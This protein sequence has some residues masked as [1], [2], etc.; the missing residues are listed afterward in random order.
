[1]RIPS[2]ILV[3]DV[4][5]FQ[6]IL[7]QKSFVSLQVDSKP[8][9]STVLVIW[10]RQNSPV[11][12]D[13][14]A[15]GSCEARTCCTPTWRLSHLP[16]YWYTA[17]QVYSGYSITRKCLFHSNTF[18]YQLPE[19][20]ISLKNDSP[21]LLCPILGTTGSRGKG[22]SSYLGSLCC[23]E[24]SIC[25]FASTATFRFTQFTSKFLIFPSLIHT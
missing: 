19:H 4:S 23:W 9:H 22:A 13:R 2:R 7:R 3:S 10:A 8:L 5:P 17:R 14:A 15:Q 24:Q 11:T 18:Y 21:P 16:H 6:W 1:M 20:S 25:Q 12:D